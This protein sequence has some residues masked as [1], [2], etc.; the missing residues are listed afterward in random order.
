MLGGELGVVGVGWRIIGQVK[1]VVEAICGRRKR[2]GRWRMAG[3]SRSEEGGGTRSRGRVS[4][5]VGGGWRDILEAQEGRGGR[6]RQPQC[7]ERRDEGGRL[8][9]TG[10][11]Q[12][13]KGDDKAAS[14]KFGVAAVKHNLNLNL[15]I[16]GDAG[17]T[18]TSNVS[19]LLDG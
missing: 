3:D 5:G 9:V 15:E 6:R 17:S 14:G 12:T 7:T 11:R 10:R 16:E 4:E 1:V 8:G 2:R 13:E 19:L 18:S